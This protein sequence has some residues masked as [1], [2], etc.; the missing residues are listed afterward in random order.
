MDELTP[1]E[2]WYCPALGTL[3]TLPE[4]VS[5]YY[6]RG[7]ECSRNELCSCKQVVAEQE[8]TRGS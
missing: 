5:L 1:R 2:L 3:G 8:G 6:A 4:M 7:V